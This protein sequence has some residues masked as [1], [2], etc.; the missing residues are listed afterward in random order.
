[1]YSL[2]LD[3]RLVAWRDYRNT[4]DSMAFAD[5][6]SSV[7]KFWNAAPISKQ[8]YSQDQFDSWPSPWELIQDD[9]V[10]D[11]SKALGMAYSLQLSKHGS[12]H[13]I[14]ICCYI[15]RDRS[16]QNNLV[17]IDHGIYVLNLGTAIH[18]NKDLSNSNYGDVVTAIKV[19]ELI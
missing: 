8:F 15:N 6:I 7:N 12:D 11:I 4:L 18:V 10:D 19:K 2:P 14:S 1:M 3:K 5:A 13:D 17:I 9:G 16:E